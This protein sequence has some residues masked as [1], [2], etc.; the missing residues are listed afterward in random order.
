MHIY[1]I[2]NDHFGCNITS[3]SKHQQRKSFGYQLRIPTNHYVITIVELLPRCLTPASNIIVDTKEFNKQHRHRQ[4][5]FV[6]YR[7]K[8]FLN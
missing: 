6:Y 1:I 4:I 5:P 3:I 7:D 8:F 2:K